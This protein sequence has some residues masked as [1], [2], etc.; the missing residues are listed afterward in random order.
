MASVPI[1]P[2]LARLAEFH[3]VETAYCDWLGNPVVVDR[4]VVVAVLAMLDVDAGSRQ[5]IQAELRAIRPRPAAAES[6]KAALPEPPRAWGWMLQAYAVRSAESWD[7]GDMADVASFTRWAAETG[8]GALLLSPL[9]AVLPTD[10]LPTSP[11][12]PSSRRFLN[13][14]YLRVEDTSAYRIADPILRAHV[15]ALR[16][17]T[18]AGLID[19]EAAWRAKKNALEM[20]WSAMPAHPSSDAFPPGGS[21][22]DSLSGFATYSALADVFGC[23]WRTWPTSLRD[24]RSS[25]VASMRGELKER[26]AFHAWLQESCDAQLATV[27]DAAAGMALG[28]VHDLAV[29]IAPGGADAW[30]MQD[31]IA[32]G[33]RIGAP[34]DGFSQQGQD[35]TVTPWRPDRLAA[36][37]YAAFRDLVRRSFKHADGLR[38]DHIAGLSRLWWLPPGATPDQ[39]AYVRY[40]SDA[41]MRILVE[42][43]V[44]AAGV[45]IGEDLGTVEAGVTSGLHDRN[46]LS[47]AVLF[48]SRDTSGRLVAPSDW[49]ELAAASVSTHD[50]PTA[51]GFLRG[52]H[53]RAA[54]QAGMLRRSEQEETAAAAEDRQSLLAV[55]QAEGLIEEAGTDEEIV[56]ALHRLLTRTPCRVLFAS[57]YDV[58]GEL[59]Q[60]NMPGTLD[61]YPNWRVPLPMHLDELF[62]DDRVRR[63]VE[64]FAGR[65]AHARA[66]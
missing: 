40:D 44:N 41:M 60:P 8:A 38:I 13:P 58:L 47:S 30:L 18:M 10:P 61:E 46:M 28:I 64:I 50:L 26:V 53:V 51:G 22:L 57:P 11:Y 6:V 33:V 2:E 63:V 31:V 35:W 24:P 25:E 45:I 14:L 62:A 66:E 39:G 54:A 48:M 49:P 59:R 27:H 20:L 5:T 9:H 37:G 3:G 4:D 1:E 55:L 21:E 42:E 16:P 36:T 15:D 19:I 23:D 12:A 29:G 43:A 34:P 52:E 32:Q 56:L 17:R 7:V 65:D